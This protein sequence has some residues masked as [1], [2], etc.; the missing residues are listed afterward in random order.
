MEVRPPRPDDLDALRRFFAAIP[1]HDRTFFKEDVLDARTVERWV[2]DPAGVRGLAC[3]G[4]DIAGYVAVVP[5]PGWSDH[6]GEVRLVVDPGRRRGGV[7]RSLARWA[8]AAAVERLDLRK[9][10]VEVVAEQDGAIGMFQA[11]GFGAEG[12]LRDH[13][14]ARDGTLRDL[15]LLSHGVDEQWS[16]MLTAGID[17][18]VG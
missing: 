15:V 9:L 4:G 6:V 3:D 10:Y 11:L 2:A 8:L 18:A 13:V 1:E 16:A 17:D 5:L 14:R 7:G 12:L